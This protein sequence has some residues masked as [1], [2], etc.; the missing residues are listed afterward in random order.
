MH[1]HMAM[2]IIENAALCGVVAW[3]VVVALCAMARQ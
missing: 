1:M 3:I 2:P